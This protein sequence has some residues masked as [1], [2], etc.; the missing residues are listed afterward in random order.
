VTGRAHITLP[1]KAKRRRLSNT[2][3]AEGA[4]I[5]CGMKSPLQSF[6]AVALALGALGLSMTA[7]GGT[8]PPRTT[9]PNLQTPNTAPP[10]VKPP[11]TP[12]TVLPPAF[13]TSPKAPVSYACPVTVTAVA[14]P[15]GK[16]G[17]LKRTGARMQ[18]LN[19]STII[20]CTYTVSADLVA[21]GYTRGGVC[22]AQGPGVI[23]TNGTVGTTTDS[24]SGCKIAG[25]FCHGPATGMK[26]T[27][28]R[29]PTS[30][31]GTCAYQDGTVELQTEVAG[32]CFAGGTP[33]GNSLSGR[34]ICW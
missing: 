24:G 2:G 6:A 26:L 11:S 29:T 8:Q 27:N 1:L 7:A 33:G 20:T 12:A 14:G 13:P 5:R 4:R 34:F 15:N 32:T 9:N 10:V 30:A 28:P 23:L 16:P 3:L 25:A 22:P 19:G 18:D 21:A 31:D 17:T